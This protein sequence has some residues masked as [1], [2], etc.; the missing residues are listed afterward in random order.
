MASTRKKVLDE[1]RRLGCEVTEQRYYGGGTVY[2]DAPLEY[3][4]S[5]THAHLHTI[6]G[7]WWEGTKDEMWLDLL[8]RLLAGVEL[9]KKPFCAVARNP[10]HCRMAQRWVNEL[11]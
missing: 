9:C 10:R 7:Q 6:C 8:D 11:S 4:F 3:V 2:I 5:Y 1:A